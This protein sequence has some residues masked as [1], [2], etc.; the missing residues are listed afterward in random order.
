MPAAMFP[1]HTIIVAIDGKQRTVR[2]IGVEIKSRL[3]KVGMWAGDE[4]ASSREK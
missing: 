3:T 2:L 1:P 4:A